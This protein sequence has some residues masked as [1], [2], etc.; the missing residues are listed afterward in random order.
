MGSVCIEPHFLDLGTSWRWVVSFTP[1][2]GEWAPGTHWIG[3]WGGPQKW[4]WRHGENS[5]HYRDSN[6]D[7]SVVQPVASRYTC[8]V[9]PAH[10]KHVNYIISDIADPSSSRLQRLAYPSGV[11]ADVTWHTFL[12][13]KKN[14]LPEIKFRWYPMGYYNG[15]NL[16]LYSGS[17][18][19]EFWL[20]SGI[21]RA[22]IAV[23]LRHAVRPGFNSRQGQEIFLFSTASRPALGPIQPPTQW[24]PLPFFR[25]E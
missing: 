2:P 1:L 24:A 7:P 22:G 12:Q 18:C 21:L 13:W 6:S 9:I 4:R 15:N 5:W 20:L 23:V 25:G 10:I 16:R 8:Y 14:T 3:N 19:F 17:T 11:F